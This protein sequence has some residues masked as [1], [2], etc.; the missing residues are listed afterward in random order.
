MLKQQII[1]QYVKQGGRKKKHVEQ[2]TEYINN[3][4]LKQSNGT[5]TTVNKKIVYFKLSKMHII[6][7]KFV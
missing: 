1:L 2:L 3:F 6:I 5:T 7:P 4:N